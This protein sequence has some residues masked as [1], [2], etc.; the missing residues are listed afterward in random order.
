MTETRRKTIA[1]ALNGTA[2][3]A[4]LII[5][6]MP[7]LRTPPPGP[8]LWGIYAMGI[9]LLVAPRSRITRKL[10]ASHSE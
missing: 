6:A 4:A 1:L 8:V 3:A 9:A 5:A 10:T 2:I 7:A